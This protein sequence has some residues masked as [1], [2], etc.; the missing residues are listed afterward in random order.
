M[1]IIHS[2]KRM[3]CISNACRNKKFKIGF[4]PTMGALHDG[5]ISLIKKARLENNTVVVSI[6][7]N[8]SQFSPQEDFNCYP[9]VIK[10][11]RLL[12]EKEG[13]DFIFYPSIKQMYPKGCRT[14]VSVEELSGVLCGESRPGHFRGV[15]TVV[16]KLF[17]I[18]CPDNA[19]FGQK[20]AQQA[21]IIKKMV[22]DLNIPVKIKT[23]PIVRQKNGLALS[24]R[25]IYL[26]DNEKEDA[27]VLFQALNSAKSLIKAGVINAARIKR[28]IKQL[29]V[30][31]KTAKIDYVA[32][33][34]LNDLQPVKQVAGGCLIALAV[35]IGK[36]RLIDNIII[37]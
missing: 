4:V 9:R 16:A 24:S 28:T 8:P 32:I 33:V 23:L 1:E 25:N 21:I 19:Y 35:Y 6:F 17:N 37:K 30:K 13:V 15:A 20:D 12:C 7:V 26:N 2:I 14:Y 34:D 3:N 5:H 22:N 18:V 29:I 11:D 36:T 31:K 27:L 10:K